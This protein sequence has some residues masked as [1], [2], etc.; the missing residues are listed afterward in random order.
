MCGQQTQVNMWRGIKAEVVK[1]SIT[2]QETMTTLASVKD[3]R[4][5]SSVGYLQATNKCVQET[6]LTRMHVRKAHNKIVT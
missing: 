6:Q 3:S 4:F 1:A 5:N 2:R